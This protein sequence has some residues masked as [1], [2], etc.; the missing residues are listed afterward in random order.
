MPRESGHRHHNPDHRPRLPGNEH[1]RGHQHHEQPRTDAVEPPSAVPRSVGLAF[2]GLAFAEPA[3]V[4]SRSG[5]L[6]FAGP[7]SVVPR[8]G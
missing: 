1:E 2:A 4:V 8:S 3:S 5:G 7:V 6:A